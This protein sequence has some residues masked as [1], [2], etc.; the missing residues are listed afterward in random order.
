MLRAKP[1]G[2]GKQVGTDKEMSKNHEINKDN[3][4]NKEISDRIKP[5]V[6]NLLL[7]LC[8]AALV[9]I[10]VFNF[11]S[12]QSLFYEEHS[13][14]EYTVEYAGVNRYDDGVIRIEDDY[15]VIAIQ[16]IGLDVKNI[17]LDLELLNSIDLFYLESGLC[18]A[19]IDVLDEGSSEFMYRL[20]ADWPVLPEN[21]TSQY[22]WIQPMGKVQGLNVNVYM[23]AGRLFR[24]NGITLN[25][26][27]P[28]DF[29]VVRFLAVWLVCLLCYGLR[30]Q[31]GWWK[32]DCKQVTIGKKA[33]LGVVFLVFY[34][35]SFYLMISN[36]TVR[37]DAYN[38]YQELAWALDAGQASLLEQPPQEL[39]DMENPYDYIA[40]GVSN[41]EY[42]YDYAYYDG[43]YYVYHGILPCLLFYL[44]VYHLTG[45]NMPNSLPVFFCCLLFGIGLVC[46]MRQVI[47][48]Y[49]PKTP[50][51]VLVLITLA[52]LFGC[53]LPFF[54][55]QP[56]SYHLTVICAAM[57]IVWGLYFWLSSLKMGERPDSLCRLFGGSFCMALVAAVRPT[58]LIYSLLAFPLFGRIWFTRREDYEKKDKIRM[59]ASFAIPY[60][61][62]AIPVMYYNYIRFG[63]VFDFGVN[64]NLTNMDVGKIPF[65]LEKIVAAVYG[66]LIKLP[67]VHYRFPYFRQPS[68]AWLEST[69][70][71]MFSGDNLFGSL[72]FF[73]SFLLAIVVVFAK[74]KEFCQKKL[75]MFS[76]MLL[77]LGIFLMILDVEM[78]GCVLYRYQADF[79]FALFMTAWMG[80]L[81]L[82]EAYAGKPSHDIFRRILIVAVFLSV[83]MNAMLW[84]VPEYMYIYSPYYY[85][86]SLPKGN[87][88]LY[89]DL[90]YG[91]N[92]W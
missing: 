36:P 1:E 33:V 55:T 46:L 4:R 31:S 30:R 72:L 58:L 82:Q 24:I 42:K 76:V 69:A 26:K 50:F 8:V 32:E 43:A 73:N 81:W 34:G 35:I 15:A 83:I 65:S 23:L 41:F 20:I 77:G 86:F 18:Y 28:L 63:S 12:I 9:E 21:L 87:T 62:V 74:R 2:R 84:F 68:E 64:Y 27:K 59:A 22:I 52:G 49:F 37:N 91:F 17:R 38:P 51:A 29:S 53:Q 78:T 67:E 11:R 16:D 48:R 75:F 10:C 90:Y 66:F 47:I 19:H 39:V 71:A 89:Y 3:K 40:R 57:L 70:H 79:T 13:W 56:V 45:L 80:I 88:Q 14:E 44:P 54:I 25:A 7:L 61:I 5:S 85:S 60:V 6:R 92:F